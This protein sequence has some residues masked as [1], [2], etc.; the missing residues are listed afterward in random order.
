MK[1]SRLLLVAVVLEFSATSAFAGIFSFGK[2]EKPDPAMR[3]PELLATL[4]ENKDEHKRVLAL[5][6]LRQYD[7][8]AFPA[9]VPA[10]IDVLLH[11][12]KPGVRS[13][14]AETLSKLR[15][16]SQPAGQAL[17]QA[18]SKDASMRVRMQARYALLQYHWAGYKSP[19]KPD[20][21]LTQS[22]EPPL[23]DKPLVPVANTTP[24]PGTSTSFKK[25][26]PPPPPPRNSDGG[27]DL[28]LPR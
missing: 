9:M 25:S 13:E 7:A 18:Q 15:P 28:G 21:M 20:G 1:S 4:K 11:D 24:M 26:L 8:A 2:K 3:V 6:E 10:V 19:K 17:E 27:P 12:P 5:D 22:D 23:A 16:V 14:A